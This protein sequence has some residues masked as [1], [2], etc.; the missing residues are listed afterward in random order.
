[1]RH[2]SRPHANPEPND[3]RLLLNGATVY[4]QPVT[5][6]V[7]S[8]QQTQIRHLRGEVTGPD[9]EAELAREAEEAERELALVA[10]RWAAI[11]IYLLAQPARLSPWERQFLSSLRRR[12]EI[13]PK[14]VRALAQI[15]H[16][17]FGGIAA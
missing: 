16:N 15:K 12:E 1:M 8:L 9:I 13:T 2:S 3:G 11:A 7:L 14:Q 10:R 4:S 17:V 6:T 5:A